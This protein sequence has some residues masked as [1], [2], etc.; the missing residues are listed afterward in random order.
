MS[1]DN[2]YYT[3]NDTCYVIDTNGKI[4]YSEV[5]KV[6]TTLKEC[7]VAYQLRDLVDYR[8]FV[9]AHESCWDTEAAAKKFKSSKMNKKETPKK[10][11]RRSKKK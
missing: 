5:V 7:D 10:I 6:F 11:K 9:A 1:K 8:Y 3:P 2:D 4:K